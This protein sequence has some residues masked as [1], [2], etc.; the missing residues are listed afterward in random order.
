MNKR[1]FF[2]NFGSR[3]VVSAPGDL[4]HDLTCG[5]AAD[6]AYRNGFGGTSGATPKVA[7]TVALMLSVNPELSHDDVRDI[8]SGTGLPL[9]EDPGKPIGVL[10]ERRGRRRRSAA[11][12]KRD[13]TR[14]GL[15][16]TPA[17]IGPPHRVAEAAARRPPSQEP[18]GAA[19]G[20]RR[21]ASRGTSRTIATAGSRSRGAAALR[22]SS[23]RPRR[24][25][26]SAVPRERRRHAHPAGS[27]PDRRAGDPDAGQLLRPSAA[28]GGDARG[29]ADP[30]AARAAAPAA[31][32]RAQ[33]SAGAASHGR[34]DVP[35]HAHADLQLGARPA[36]QLPA[37]AAVSRLHRLPAVRGG[38]VLRGRPAALSRHPGRA[39]ISVRRPRRSDPAR[40]CSTGTACRSSAPCG[41][42]PIRRPAATRPRVMRAA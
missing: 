42:M 3:V 19:E 35:Q 10:S 26:A 33:R 7:G 1:A 13:R 28:Q 40:S 9:T 21:A 41:R 17:R 14:P 2:S 25:D 18:D 15:S 37:A 5:Q 36:H 16:S 20:Y 30:A 39:R 11:P 24:Q 8:L 34:A 23:R 12:P 32:G 38:A 27:D 4:Q 29:P 31:A 6:N 22:A